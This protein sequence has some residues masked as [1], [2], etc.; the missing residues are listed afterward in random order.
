MQRFTEGNKFEQGDPFDILFHF[1]FVFWFNVLLQFNCSSCSY[2]YY[3]I[4]NLV[5]KIN[6]ILSFWDEIYFIINLTEAS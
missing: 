5:F 6:F 4:I 2:Y 3:C 1:F